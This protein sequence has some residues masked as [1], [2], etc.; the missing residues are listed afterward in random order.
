M[1]LFGKLAVASTFSPRFLPM[2]AEAKSVATLLE[3][4]F[5]IIHAGGET[6][7]NRERFDQAF[8][9]LDVSAPIHWRQADL[10]SA[11]ILQAARE[12]EV[13]LL[14]AGA[15]ERDSE[16]RYFLGKVS[17]VLVREAPCSLLLFANPS[18]EAPPF[19]KLAVIVDFSDASRHALRVAFA[20]A[21]RSRAETVHVLRVF[22]V[23]AQVLAEP[24]EFIK[25][26]DRGALAAEEA[27]L[28]QFVMETGI[29]EDMEIVTRC[30]EGTTGFAAADYVQSIGADLLAVPGTAADGHANFPARMEWL[31]NVIPTNLLVIRPVMSSRESDPD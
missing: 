18:R 15:M 27:R 12:H 16:G 4:P 25:G 19:R 3:R 13:G 8:A 29:P 9:E 2:L 17:R 1:A 7:E 23:F 28:D 11:A 31:E 14:L 24:N 21:T 20:L 5:E 26:E 6:P 30:I 10:P 22:T